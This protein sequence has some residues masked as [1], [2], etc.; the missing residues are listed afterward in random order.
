MIRYIFRR[1]PS[2]VIV[3]A[4]ASIVAFLLPRL[5][6]GDPA[7]QMAGPDATTEQV[8]AI[9]HAAGLDL[10][11]VTQ[12]LNWVGG[13]FHGDL[14]TSF[15]YHRPVSELIAASMESSFELAIFA[16]IIMVVLALVLGVL[17]GTQLRKTSRTVLDVIN[18]A[19]IA[20]PAFLVGLILIVVFGIVLRVLPISGQVNL[21]ENFAEG[22]KYLI[23][24]AI[25]LALGQAAVI[26]RL[27]QTS[28]LTTRGEEFV[29]LATAKGASPARIT[30]RHVLPASL[31]TAIVALGLRI[32][33]LLGGAIVIEAI[34][35]RSGLGQLAVQA[36]NSR[37]YFLVQALVIGAVMIA[38]LSQLTSELVTA[39]VDPRVRLDG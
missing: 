27:L 1:I 18:T 12:Y 9:R 30:F 37:D 7:V 33:E 23:L 25:A 16:A 15:S 13:I 11:L 20:M 19:M 22:I 26:A 21:S 17:G 4:L 14:G 35:S 39:A 8:D 31:N 6:P 34:F 32:G 3:V 38:V 10:P 28:M 5:A 2:F 24:P 29:D 36:V